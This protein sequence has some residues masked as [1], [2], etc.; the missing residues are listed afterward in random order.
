MGVETRLSKV[1][2]DGDRI[3]SKLPQVVRFCKMEVVMVVMCAAVLVLHVDTVVTLSCG[4]ELTSL[5]C[6]P[7]FTK[8]PSHRPK[9]YCTSR[10]PRLSQLEFCP[11]GQLQTDPCGICL[12]CAPGFGN[13]CGGLNNERGVCAGGL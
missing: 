10:C 9:C 12:E 13:T 5:K 3:G 1:V 4:R 2:P 7:A 11:S 6:L 8:F